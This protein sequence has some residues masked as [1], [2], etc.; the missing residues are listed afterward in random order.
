MAYKLIYTTKPNTYNC[1]TVTKP[2]TV[3]SNVTTVTYSPPKPGSKDVPIANRQGHRLRV[4]CPTSR[5][6]P[7]RPLLQTS[8]VKDHLEAPFLQPG[9]DPSRLGLPQFLPLQPHFLDIIP[10]FS[11]IEKQFKTFQ[12][13][14]SITQNNQHR[15]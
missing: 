6:T 12:Q 11:Q 15:G 13:G 7:S 8:P 4:A 9:S 3:T 1:T 10:H 2:L 5:L 14:K